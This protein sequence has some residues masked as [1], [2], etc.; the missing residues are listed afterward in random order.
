MSP[1]QAMGQPVDPRSDLFS[2]GSVLYTLCTGRPAFRADS[3]IAVLRRVC[4]DTPRPIAEI[5]PEVPDWLIAMINRLLSKQS[6]DRYQT[7]Q[8]VFELFSQSLAH[9]AQPNLV[10]LPGSTNV[11]PSS[12]PGRKSASPCE[13]NAG[14]SHWTLVG[15]G[16]FCAVIV[17]G[18]AVVQWLRP[19][20]RATSDETR[21]NGAARLT[22]EEQGEKR[23]VTEAAAPL[24]TRAPF[25]AVQAR[26]HQEA[27]AKHLGVPVEWT[28]NIGM[29]FRL[30]PP[31]Q[32]QMGSSAAELAALKEELQ[33][34][35]TADFDLFVSQSSGPRHRVALSQPFYIGQYEVTVTQYRQFLEETGYQSS[36]SKA[37]GERFRWQQFVTE[38][39]Q[40]KQ[41]ICGVSWEDAENYC[42]WL[43][44]RASKEPSR[45]LYG[46]PTEAQWEYACRAGTETL[47]VSGDD[48]EALSEFAIF[49]QT[50]TFG[51]APVGLRRENSF[52]LFDMHGNVE[53]WCLDWHNHG[54]YARS[55]LIDPLFNDPPSE[56]GSGKV[57][58]GGAWNCK[59]WSLRSTT[60]NYDFPDKP[61]HARGFRVVCQVGQARR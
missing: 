15:V 20:A 23:L 55:P 22:S 4:D 61:T 5:N 14:R 47:W 31:G 43:N 59:P 7:A 10:P 33:T 30:I 12:S 6:Q 41:P 35:G 46:L 26:N 48:V 28:N 54:Y 42:Q 60:R 27:W 49:G 18:I 16:F 2:L 19:Q 53:E 13:T 8:E 32:F 44:T 3:T 39:D 56:K 24:P 11:T 1:E 57:A 25:D 38:G 50:N 40:Q 9:L 37:G 52:G 21:V 34:M 45:G 36:A 58:R 51:P 17:V 29:R